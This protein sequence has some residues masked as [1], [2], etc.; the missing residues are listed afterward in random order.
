MS[1]KTTIIKP[2][3]FSCP[4]CGFTF[5]QEIKTE[6]KLKKRD[7]EEAFPITYLNKS[8]PEVDKINCPNCGEIEV[9]VSILIKRPN[10]VS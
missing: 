8:D 3:T 6:P 10:G 1:D 5:Q 4:V 7:F 9:M 2:I